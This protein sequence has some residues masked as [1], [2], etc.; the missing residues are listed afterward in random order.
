MTQQD[1]DKPEDEAGQVTIVP[2]Y[3]GEKFPPGTGEYV[4][5]GYHPIRPASRDP[6]D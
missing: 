6:R 4:M 3:P 2:K 5:P 1:S